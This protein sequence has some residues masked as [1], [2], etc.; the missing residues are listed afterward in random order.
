MFTEN[1]LWVFPTDLNELL[2]LE[3]QQLDVQ[4]IRR[5]LKDFFFFGRDIEAKQFRQKQP[6]SQ[7]EYEL[8]ELIARIFCNNFIHVTK[9]RR[10]CIC[11]K[12]N[13]KWHGKIPVEHT[14]MEEKLRNKKG[15]MSSSITSGRKMTK[16]NPY[17]DSFPLTYNINF[18]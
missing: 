5:S 1:G 6:P 14:R 17:Q 9:Q 7:Q 8:I 3:L 4:K 2:H 10:L 13:I 12:R 15:R 16:K 18:K 11:S